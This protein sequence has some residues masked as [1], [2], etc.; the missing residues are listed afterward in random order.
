MRNV[1]TLVALSAR[2]IPSLALKHTNIAVRAMLCS[3]CN[4]LN[5]GGQVSDG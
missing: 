3:K 2:L 5:N 1:L 4:L